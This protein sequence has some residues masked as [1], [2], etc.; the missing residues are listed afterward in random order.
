MASVTRVFVYG[1]LRRG[2]ANH[3]LLAAAR[4]V[5]DARTMPQF[6][7]YALDGHPGMG[8]G[9]N[10]SVVGECFDV[11]VTTLAA[12]DELEGYPGWYDRIELTLAGGER[13]TAYLLPPEFTAGCAVIP[14][15]DWVGWRRAR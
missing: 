13:A 7:L 10:T 3:H 5:C 12:L 6:T 8:V 9:G 4:F 15:G 14:E 2:E 11:D 1:T